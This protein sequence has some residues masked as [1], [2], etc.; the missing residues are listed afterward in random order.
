MTNLR[1]AVRPRAPERGRARDGLRPRRG[2]R[3]AGGGDG[4]G[5][6][7]RCRAAHRRARHPHVG[8]RGGDRP[9]RRH[10]RLA[11][12]DAR[13]RPD[14][15]ARRARLAAAQAALRDLEAGARPAEL[16]RAAAELRVGRGRGRRARSED[17]KRLAPLAAVGDGE[18]AGL[19]RGDRGGARGGR[20]ARCRARVAAT[21]ARGDASRADPGG[22]RR[23][24]ERA[25]GARRRGGERERPRAD[26]AGGGAWC[27]AGTPSRER[28]CA[29]ASPRSRSAIS[30]T[31]GCASS[32]TSSALPL[33]RVGDAGDARCSTRI[34]RWSSRGASSRCATRRSSRRG[35]R[36]P[37]TSARTCCSA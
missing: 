18:R 28:C 13:T 37:R 35:W 4:R 2:A 34:R 9:R 23:R 17:V 15:D 32:W 31:P 16:D 11:H 25:R 21:A 26:G 1:R 33:I 22:A 30:R 24:R 3:A 6:R 5:H 29:P 36:S 12:G 7:G 10:A 8:G 27:S 19:R 14:V 20:A